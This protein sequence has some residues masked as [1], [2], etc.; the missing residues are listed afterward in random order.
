MGVTINTMAASNFDHEVIV[1]GAGLSGIA[2]GI[3][4][5]K[6][7][8]HDFAILEKEADVGGTW[9]DNTY[10]GLAVDIPTLTYSYSFEQNPDWSNLYAPGPELMAYADHCTDK[11]GVRPHIQFNKTISKAV[12][13]RDQ[14][15]WTTYL[16]SGES[17]TCRYL[18]SATGFLQVA[19]MPDIKGMDEFKGKK[20]HTARWDHEHDLSGERVAVIGTGATAIQLIPQIAPI[21]KNLSVFQRTPIW[22]LPKADLPVSER[23]Q[24]A[25]RYIP[26]FQRLL[27]FAIW[28]LTDMVVVNVLKDYKRFSWLADKAERSCTAHI[29]NQVKDPEIQEKLIPK[30]TFG[31]KR[32]S[33]S[34]NFYPVFNRE[35]CEL[36]TEPIERICEDGII[37]SDGEVREIDTLICATGF[38]VFEKKAVPTFPIYGKNGVEITDFWEENRYQ[39]FLG[40]SVPNYPNYFM[41]FGP[42]SIASASFIAMIENQTRHLIRCLKTARKRGAD[43]IEVK[44]E[45]HD[46]DFQKMLLRGKKMVWALG[47]CQAANTYNIDR[48]G[49]FP[50]LRP[51]GS[52]T[53]W[54]K[55]HSFSMS[56]YDF[57]SH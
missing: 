26:G 11:Y 7:G 34:N 40:A 35:N 6:A 9:R 36:V 14:N 44:Q 52:V 15:L 12:Y 1:I 51:V 2:T 8:F 41:I 32:P 29:R 43:C 25:L 50:G 47:G 45:S 31:C 24:K 54:W 42:Y 19:K 4:L 3:K 16:E 46:R 33:F 56:N 38:E 30:Y 48:H 5:R 55:S 10:P 49:D 18:V 53:T 39:A 21:V 13:D 27:R 20:I 22:L 28:L 23:M 17:L 57:T 37:T